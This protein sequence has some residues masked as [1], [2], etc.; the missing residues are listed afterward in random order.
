MNPKEK[1][2]KYTYWFAIVLSTTCCS[3]KERN[4]ETQFRDESRKIESPSLMLEY[5]DSLMIFFENGFED[6]PIRI[7]TDEVVLL[8]TISTSEDVGLADIK[9]LGYRNS[10]KKVSVY[11]NDNEEIKLSVDGSFRFIAINY[12][13]DKILIEYLNKVPLYE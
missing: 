8:D 7:N 1:I 9:N 12:S 4:V 10:I 3:T 5:G 6:T 13:P 2:R 11:I